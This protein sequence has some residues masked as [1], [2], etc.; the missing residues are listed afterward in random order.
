MKKKRRQQWIAMLMTVVMMFQTVSSVAMAQ[1]PKIDG[2]AGQVQT[3]PSSD[4][5]E[6]ELVLPERVASWSQDYETAT[7]QEEADAL[8]NQDEDVNLLIT[9]KECELSGLKYGE[10]ASASCERLDLSEMTAKLLS[11]G[12]SSEIQLK[13]T[14][15]EQLIIQSE[16]EQEVTLH[17]D[18]DT[19]V[20]EII[21]E[22]NGSVLIEGN[23]A[24]GLV[25][26]TGALKKAT[27]RA[28]CSVLNESGEEVQLETPD[29]EMALAAG[30]QEELVLSSYMVTFMADGQVYDSK[31]VKP[32][33]TI[34]FPEQN[35][36]KE[37]YIFT[38]WYKDE[39][40]TESCS[41]FE[42]ADGEKVFYARFVEESESIKVTFDCMGGRELEPQIFAKGETLLTRPI[43]EIYTEKE[44]YS[45]GGWCT[46]P[47]CTTAFSY[48]QPLEESMTLYAFFV[49][50]EVQTTE[51]DG[52][53]ADMKD[54]D[55]QGSIP[56]RTEEK[57]TLE[58][59]EKNIRVEAGSGALEP[60]LDITETEDGFE[61]SGS[62]Y[63]KDGETGFEPGATFSIILSGGVHFSD[64]SDD[65]D[66]AVVSVYKERVEVVGFSENMTYVL[67]DDVLEYSPIVLAED[68]PEETEAE[69]E[70]ETST[71]AEIA[72]ETGE[73]PENEAVSETETEQGQ[74]I[75]DPDGDAAEEQ[76]G[77]AYI[78]GELLVKD[79]VSYQE[80]DI[81]AFY[82]GEIGRDEKNI[83]AYTEG[84]LD[85]YV[86]F[87]QILSVEDTA[88]GV[89]LTYGYASPEDYLADFDVHITDDVEMDQQLSDE[90]LEVLTSRLSRQVEENEELKAQMMVAVM[91]APETQDMLDDMYG[92]GVYSLAGMN[93]ILTP[94]KP[95][96][97]LKVSGS[98]VTATISISATAKI[99]KDGKALLTIQPKLAFTQSLSVQTN[100]DGG[101]VWID[102]AITIRSMS[103]IE[104]TVTATTGGKTSVFTKAKD[105]LTEI[106]KPEGIVEGEYDS[107]DESVSDLMDT[108]NSIV[109]TSLKY[110]DLFDILL[111]NLKFSFYGIITVGFEVHLVGQVGVLATFGVEIV[112]RSG[113]RIGFKYNFLK[114]KGSSYT[115]KL[116]SSVTNNIY[117]IGKVG[118]RVGLRLT[119]SV[120]LCG[121][122]SAYITGS[123]YAYAELT[124]LFFNTTNLLTGA[125]TN[126]GA[127]KFEVGIDVVVSL[128][129]KVNLIIKTVR[130]S[131]TVFSG[132]W[133]LW[134]T[135]ISSKMSY[136]D[137]E[138]LSKLWEKSTAN[139]DRKS[140]FGFEAVPMKTWD[141]LNGNCQKNEQLF[142]KSEKYKLSI[143]NLTLDGESVPSDDPRNA[144]FTV[145]TL[146]NNQNPGFIYMDEL[147]VGQY[148]C[149]E[150]ALDL[151]LTYEDHS[152]SALVKK[153]VQRFHLEKKCELSTTTQKV[154]VVLYDWCARN[155]GIEAAEWDNAQVFETSFFSSHMIG[156]ICEQ[157]ATGTLDLGEVIVAAQSLYPELSG[158]DYSWGEP[159]KDGT[160]ASIQYSSPRISNFCF[161]T[162]DN[163][164]VRFDVYPGT[165]EYEVTYYLFI[166]RFEGFENMVNYHI[167]LNSNSTEN[168]YAFSVLPTNET[169]EEQFTKDENGVYNLSL[170]RSVFDGTQCPIKL[171][172]NGGDPASTGFTVT[173]R[174]YQKDVYFDMNFGKV[175]LNIALGEG[176]EEYQFANP[177]QMSEEGIQPGEKVELDVTL[178]EGYGGLE[179]LSE[180]ETIDFTVT[181][182]KVSFVMPAQDLTITLQAYKKHSILYQYNYGG[183]DEYQ[184]VYFTE[185]EVTR[186]VET[187]VIDG[188]T[189]RGWY[190]TADCSGEPYQFGETLTTDLILYADWTCNVTVSFG[191][192][193]GKAEY[194]TGE[195]ENQQ[196]QLVFDG[197]ESEYYVFTYSTL[198]VGDK[199][200]NIQTPEYEGY[201][202]MDWYLDAEFKTQKLNLSSYILTGGVTI[203]AKWARELELTYDRNDPVPNDDGQSTVIQQMVGYEGYP[204]PFVPE[205]PE[206]LYYSFTGWYRNPA[207][208]VPFDVT[209]DVLTADTTLYAGWEPVSYDITY[210]L[211]GGE[212]ASSNPASYTT[213]DSFVLEAPTK[214][215]YD[216]VGWTGTGLEDPVEKVIV[217]MGDGGVRNYLAHWSPIEY[218]IK[219]EKTYD[220]AKNN[221]ETYTIKSG[222]IVLEEP[223]REKYKFCGWVGTDLTKATKDVTIP[224][225]S[226]GNRTYRATW[227]T[228]DP[229]ERI[230]QGVELLLE[231]NPYNTD[232]LNFLIAEDFNLGNQQL[233]EKLEPQV[234][235]AV[236]AQLKSMVESDV[237]GKY[238]L[239]ENRIEIGAYASSIELNATQVS[240]DRT[241]DNQK[242][243]YTYKVSIQYTDE[244]STVHT[245]EVDYTVYLD[246]LVPQVTMPEMKPLTYGQKVSESQIDK[247]GSASYTNTELGADVSS[248]SGGFVWK[249]TKEEDK[250]PYGLNN[251]TENGEYKMIFQPSGNAAELYASVEDSVG[252]ITQIG[253]MV[254]VKADDR[255]YNPG[256][257]S[258]TGTAELYYVNADGTEGEKV[259]VSGLLNEGTF[260][261]DNAIAGEG[262]DVHYSGYS[263]NAAVN[264]DSTYGKNVYHLVSS[265]AITVQATIKQV[266]GDLMSVAY[267]ANRS[268]YQYGTMLSAVTF[269]GTMKYG[270]RVIDG[271]WSWVNPTEKLNSIPDSTHKIRFTPTDTSGGY[272][273]SVEKEVTVKVTKKTVPV[274]TVTT[275]LTYNGSNQNSGLQGVQ[276]VYT[277]KDDGGTNAGTYRATL[278]L[279]NPDYYCWEGT[280]ET[281]VE[282]PYTIAKGTATVSG[283][284][285]CSGIAYGQKL[286]TNDQSGQTGAYLAT[287]I[288]GLQVTFNGKT[289]NGRWEWKLDGIQYGAQPW[290][291]SE[292]AYEVPIYFIPSSETDAKNIE[293]ADKNVS[294]KVNKATP[295]TSQCGITASMYQTQPTAIYTLSSAKVNVE[296]KPVNQYTGAEIAGSWSWEGGDNVISSSGT[297]KYVFTPSSSNY[298]EVSVSVPVTV[299]TPTTVG[300]TVRAVESLS[301]PWWPT[302]DEAKEDYKGGI[303]TSGILTGTLTGTVAAPKGSNY[304]DNNQ[305]I[306]FTLDRNSYYVS[307]IRV[308]AIGYRYYSNSSSVNVPYGEEHFE[309]SVESAS[310][311]KYCDDG[312][313]SISGNTY[314]VKNLLKF[315]LA[316]DSIEVEVVVKSKNSSTVLSA[317]RASAMRIDNTTSSE[318]ESE[319]TAST[320]T[321]AQTSEPETTAPEKEAQTSASETTTSETTAPE[322]ESDTSAP[323][324]STPETS[325]PETESETSAPETTA[326]EKTAPETSA[327]AETEAQVSPQSETSAPATEAQTSAPETDP[328]AAEADE[329]A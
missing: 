316:W 272:E 209:S 110:N 13:G 8:R 148:G 4:A 280:N 319:T 88:D 216:F 81:V 86:L 9:A 101:A 193:K 244:S 126:L 124:G 163:G 140:V 275:S 142:A 177:E 239:A 93:A 134:S 248:V 132:R 21:L 276:G 40:F 178:K 274:P 204:V 172:V 190:T 130:K 314:T 103:K 326:L 318:A 117:L 232:L 181:D 266:S 37:G 195:E 27:V 144:I 281:S 301:T 123:L 255:Y 203:Y 197:D 154:K 277:V 119:F 57:M 28:T 230:L 311:T 137:E 77:A 287:N 297:R 31:A 213:E 254:K 80:G 53:S 168:E 295:D 30:Q 308:K 202:F 223:E 294:V 321:E 113:E 6:T 65:T 14:E 152:S 258:A 158:L 235:A 24:L 129:L 210:D 249:N 10:I 125:N 98:E 169:K 205:D 283:T 173:G 324:T 139:A 268:T 300:Y 116:E 186:E 43:N 257:T 64:Y 7:T 2:T 171:S 85:G 157:N 145:G 262:K 42:A 97:K 16:E 176:V 50:E 153:Q 111:L 188:L 15:L 45:F 76:E 194:I 327:P 100:V 212:N 106:V 73:D 240:V 105:S 298:Q 108:M 3:E 149:N 87:A 32:G 234:Q 261:F 136:M 313:V 25:R 289:I 233:N 243:I 115:E 96:I 329:A 71:E 279:T 44:G 120:T 251:G 291:V 174:E 95:V 99:M 118:A 245:R 179:V 170:A 166:R 282:V 286:M 49:S 12:G 310:G 256:D 102:M 19:K 270:E 67:W 128:G 122:A 22:G 247:D 135:S 299:N 250:V 143:E 58:E 229:T 201:Q 302:S 259:T 165:Q 242:Q 260:T 84:S 189:F 175:Q 228:T 226:T 207:A 322:T 5:A 236:N 79:T 47:E 18:A 304:S 1:S 231:Q 296:K 264:E 162:T 150:I 35:P 138:E 23:G 246:K 46:D 147:M 121:I 66:T 55:W 78:P 222:D 328:P 161:M 290:D 33:E 315:I 218:T 187:P 26:V 94:G 288:S 54:F 109:S 62:Y 63:E 69:S 273:L 253:V 227:E 60:V 41:Q 20:P 183:L 220:S 293:I 61:I 146:G 198:H 200:L 285:S 208:T 160:T 72:S 156:G 74:S 48:T 17:I 214:V 224:A 263:L 317:R 104:L 271:T 196:V 217:E 38:T 185:N 141:L 241:G 265:D 92:E 305:I 323:E 211:D 252:L 278:T 114:F 107:Y 52:T 269:D 75:S 151:V 159:V 56:L 127:L 225:G 221:P 112:A 292:T 164:V 68:E 36:E 267:P 184:K 70:T 155:W 59:V 90:D 309:I 89:H 191:P 133:P 199:L 237:D 51:K 192:V 307:A 29:G 180:N 82:D 284:A 131:W 83:D 182:E 306:S 206:Y 238:P 303:T 312:F 91:S 34:V 219:Y 325:A 215:G 39:E 320:E 167:R 11:V